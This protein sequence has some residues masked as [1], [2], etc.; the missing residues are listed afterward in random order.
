MVRKYIRR[1]TGF[2]QLIIARSIGKSTI[3]LLDVDNS[4]KEISFNQAMEEQDG[5]FLLS[6]KY[7]KD[8][9]N[10]EYIHEYFLF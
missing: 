9:D 8:L 5:L 10:P 3:E 2:G 1:V 6:S 4:R 7:E